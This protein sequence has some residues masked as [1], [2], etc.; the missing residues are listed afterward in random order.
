MGCILMAL[1]NLGFNLVF[2]PQY[3]YSFAVWAFVAANVFYTIWTFIWSQKYEYV[4]FRIKNLFKELVI[5]ILAL[6]LTHLFNQRFE[7]YSA[8]LTLLK[9]LEIT[10]YGFYIYKKIKNL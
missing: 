7:E 6:L 10:V 3:G 2:V 9:T 5:F 8:L 1:V 4:N